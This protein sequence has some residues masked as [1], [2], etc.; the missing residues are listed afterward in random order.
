MCGFKLNLCAAQNKYTLLCQLE[1][2][3]K[4]PEPGKI[5]KHSNYAENIQGVQCKLI[6]MKSCLLGGK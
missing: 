5:T 1:L 4:K 2:E 6:H 3:A